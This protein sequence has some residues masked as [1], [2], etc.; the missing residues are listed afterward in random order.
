MKF[1]GLIVAIF[2]FALFTSISLSIGNDA[3]QSNVP[4]KDNNSSKDINE[5]RFYIDR[6]NFETHLIRHIP[7][8]Q[9]Y[10]DVLPPAGAK[11]ITYNSGNLTLK[12][13]LSDDLKDDRKH[14]AVVYA[15]GGFSFGGSDWE[16]AQEFLNQSFVLMTP[17][18][19][20][21]WQSRRLR[22]FLWRG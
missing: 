9:E 3:I 14:P 1:R 21:E 20:G 11:E 19:R 17:T 2:L 5:S 16:D 18:L 7:A 13:W 10:G 12:A 6:S 4:T 22:I 8:P 15:H